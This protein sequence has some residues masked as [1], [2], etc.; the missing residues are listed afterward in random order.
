ML[1]PPGVCLARPI[2]TTKLWLKFER[3]RTLS[4]ALMM[5]L[6]LKL[7]LVAFLL[8]IV[9]VPLS[10]TIGQTPD[11][12]RKKAF[13]LYRE[14]NLVEALPL[15]EKLVIANPSDRESIEALGFLLLSQSV[16]TK[17]PVAR[18]AGRLRGRDLLVRAEQLGA[19]DLLLK[20]TIAGI[21]ADGGDDV[22]FS[23][24]KEVD[25]AMREGEASF[26]KREYS[27]AIRSYQIALLFDTKQ[28]A[29]A[30][31]I[32]DAY[33]QM[34][35]PVEAGE[36]FGRAVAI[37]PNRETAYRYWGDTLMKQGKVL[38]ARDKFIEAYIAEPYSRFTQA[39]FSHWGKENNTSLSH[40]RIEIPT[41]VTPVENG[42]MT[43]NLDPRILSKDKDA[44][45]AAWLMYGFV[46]ATWASDNFAREFPDEKTYRHS[47]REEAAALRAVVKALP[48]NENEVKKVEQTL[49]TLQ[50]LENDGLLEAYILLA[51]PDEGI[52]R[53]FPSYRQANIENL[54]RYVKE[55]VLPK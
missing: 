35:Q 3:T 50:K 48:K 2:L 13:Q 19:D 42:K 44:S 39:A 17:D 10:V 31:F 45:A 54:R 22:S 53:D 52:S 29:A 46:R 23:P 5:R 36:W 11:T 40:P 43:I 41:S 4:A 33:Y 51:M 38:E 25:D 27:K 6:R 37:N 34:E 9:F 15:F 55:Y 20:N 14:G 1:G 30:L 24:K 26:A 18:K 32:G 12:D 16:Y 47:L 8:T 28:Y 49:L 21:A 7:P